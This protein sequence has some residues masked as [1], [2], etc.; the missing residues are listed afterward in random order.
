MSQGAWLTERAARNTAWLKP[1]LGIMYNENASARKNPLEGK[2]AAKAAEN[3][4]RSKTPPHLWKNLA[5]FYQ[6]L[7]HRS[8]LLP[9][10]KIHGSTRALFKLSV[11][12]HAL[13]KSLSSAEVS[14][15]KRST[16]KMLT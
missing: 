13:G 7:A 10:A 6:L 1:H 4:Q 5:R 14:E 16:L 9:S 8:M 12:V 3:V 11:L 2:F 15:S